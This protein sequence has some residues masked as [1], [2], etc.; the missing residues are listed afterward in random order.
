MLFSWIFSS[1]LVYSWMNLSNLVLPPTGI[2]QIVLFLIILLAW[3]KLCQKGIKITVICPGPID[4]STV[5]GATSSAQ[6]SSSKVSSR[7]PHDSSICTSIKD[8][9]NGGQMELQF[10]LALN[11]IP[12]L[13]ST[14]Y[15]FLKHY[16]LFYHRISYSIF[17]M[18]QIVCM[19]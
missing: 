12:N 13:S 2:F 14:I 11:G 9:S 3:S 17:F 10:L 1:L 4:T 8:Y 6:I 7:V 16:V 19:I 18:L 5:P 15:T